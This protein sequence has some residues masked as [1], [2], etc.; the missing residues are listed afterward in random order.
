MPHEHQAIASSY[1]LSSQ[2]HESVWSWHRTEGYRPLEQKKGVQTHP[3]C[4][5]DVDRWE[6][7][8]CQW[9]LVHDTNEG[10]VPN[11]LH[12]SQVQIHAQ[13]RLCGVRPTW[14][15]CKRAKGGDVQNQTPSR[16]Q[17]LPLPAVPSANDVH[18][19]QCHS[20][21]HFSRDLMATPAATTHPP[22]LAAQWMLPTR[23]APYGWGWNFLRRYLFSSRKIRNMMNPFIPSMLQR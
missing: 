13:D 8:K 9:F 18:I 5:Q 1:V 4:Y 11:C 16:H 20:R 10:T 2:S 21:L 15:W 14:W 23:C 3:I 22:S 7:N 19:R 12:Q 6:W 17:C